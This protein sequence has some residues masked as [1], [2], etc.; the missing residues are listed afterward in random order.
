MLNRDGWGLVLNG[1]KNHYDV[2]R[3]GKLL[4]DEHI[5]QREHKLLQG[6]QLQT[7]N[8]FFLCM[9]ALSSWFAFQN[10]VRDMIDGGIFT[11]NLSIYPL[12]RGQFYYEEDVE[13]IVGFNLYDYLQDRDF[14]VNDLKKEKGWVYEKT[15]VP[16]YAFAPDKKK[17]KIDHHHFVDSSGKWIYVTF[18]ASLLNLSLFL[19]FLRNLLLLL[20]YYD[21]VG[22]SVSHKL[23]GSTVKTCVKTQEEVHEGTCRDVAFCYSKL[24]EALMEIPESERTKAEFILLS[25]E[26][27]P[28]V[29]DL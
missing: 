20:S 21:R 8:Y 29:T 1:M 17:L 22:S 16:A 13:P 23:T 25:E 18:S 6:Q 19:S 7:S 27:W 2:Y 3:E 15:T 11:S 10:S 5:D 24:R 12:A 9:A 4:N 26:H 28:S 14:L